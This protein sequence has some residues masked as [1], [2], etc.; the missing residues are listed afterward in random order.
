M[1]ENFKGYL[2][3]IKAS[4]VIFVLALTDPISEIDPDLYCIRVADQKVNV[5]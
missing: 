2:G 1:M 3:K 5:R 4:L